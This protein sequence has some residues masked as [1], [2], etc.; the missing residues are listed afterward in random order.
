VQNVSVA[1]INIFKPHFS[2][3]VIWRYCRHSTNVKPAGL[4]VKSCLR[5]CD[6]HHVYL[7]IIV[8]LETQ[9]TSK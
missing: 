7:E 4:M 2:N 5:A 9:V 6:Y 8:K 1:E 3:V